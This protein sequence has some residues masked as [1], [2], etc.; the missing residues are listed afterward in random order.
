MDL[1]VRPSMAYPAHGD[2]GVKLVFIDNDTTI[3][4]PMDALAAERFAREI[5]CIVRERFGIR[6]AVSRPSIAKVSRPPGASA[7]AAAAGPPGGPAES[8]AT[9]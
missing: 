3:R 8:G 5:R 9:G 4:V 6:G 2:E 1:V 7:P